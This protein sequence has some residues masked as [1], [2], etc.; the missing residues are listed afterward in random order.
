M[1]TAASA[2]QLN[3]S[4]SSSSSRRRPLKDST[5]GFCQ[6][7][8]GSMNAVPARRKLT[9]VSERVRGQLR[10]VVTAHVRGRAALVGEALEHG[11][12]LV[13]VDAAGDVD[14]ERLAGELVND[15]EQLDHAAVGGLI[16]LEVQRPDLIGPL[17]PQPVGRDRRLA[18]ALALAPASG[19]PEA[20]FA[21]EPLD[22][23]GL[24]WWP[25]SP[26]RTCARR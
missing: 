22:A 14:R 6:G 10:S 1:T 4:T 11:H 20:F 13:G 23:L 7:E 25:S 12:G 26:R 2:R 17:R 15:V 5:N 24:T 9:P 16:E 21:P 3:C 18:Q 19:D 8:P